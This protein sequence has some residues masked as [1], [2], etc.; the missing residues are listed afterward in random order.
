MPKKCVHLGR[1]STTP[2]GKFKIKNE[3]AII[4]SSFKILSAQQATLLASLTGLFSIILFDVD[5]PLYQLILDYFL[6]AHLFDYTICF[7][8]YEA[9]KPFFTQKHKIICN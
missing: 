3:K 7:V 4:S 6:L 9:L 5:Y 1:E 8:V 2:R